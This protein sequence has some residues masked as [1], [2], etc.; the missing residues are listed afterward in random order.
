MNK[1]AEATAA[2]CSPLNKH[3]V[4]ITRYFY[5]FRSLRVFRL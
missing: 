3:E 5:R 4:Q 1:S 2:V